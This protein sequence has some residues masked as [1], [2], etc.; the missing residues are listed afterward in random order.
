MS[1]P[2]TRDETIWGDN[3]D[4]WLGNSSDDDWEET[5]W[6]WDGKLAL[7][8][9]KVVESSF[10]W[11]WNKELEPW[12][13]IS[14]TICRG[15]P[16]SQV[17]CVSP[18][19]RKLSGPASL[20]RRTPRTCFQTRTGKAEVSRFN[21]KVGGRQEHW[22]LGRRQE[23]ETEN[24]IKSRGQGAAKELYREKSNNK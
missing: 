3:L 12:Q 17:N 22:D 10:W 5:Q 14:L 11:L 4:T 23:E 20:A 1:G 6:C 16:Y 2:L 7:I 9:I 19:N 8:Q 13:N 15:D 21:R 18:S 24:A